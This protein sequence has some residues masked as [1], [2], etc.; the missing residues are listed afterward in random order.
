[1]EKP[2]T[3][4]NRH[5]FLSQK[6]VKIP[7]GSVLISK[8]DTRGIITYANDM[9][10]ETCGFSREELIGKSHNIVRHPDVPPSVFKWLWDTLQTGRPW[11]GIVK[12]RCK[13]GDHYWV[14]ATIA[15]IMDN[16]RVIGYVSVR[17]LPDLAE[18]HEAESVYRSLNESGKPVISRWE[19]F[20]FKN[21]T[22]K[23][24]L[25]FSILAPLSVFFLAGQF[26]V[27]AFLQQTSKTDDQAWMTLT[28]MS[29]MAV[30]LYFLIGYC[31]DRFVRQPLLVANKT[32]N[33]I[34]EGN[35]GNELDISTQDETGDLL[36][37]I[38]SMQCYLRTMVDEIVT[39]VG[40]I[41]KGIMDMDRRVSSVADNSMIELEHIQQIAST[42]EQFSQSVAEVAHMAS[43]SLD[44]ANATQK[45]IDV[46]TERMQQQI[47]PAMSKAIATAQ[48][49]SKT[50]VELSEAIKNIGV[51]TN[52]IKE[53][54][55]QTNLLALNAAI[56]AAR[57][58][59]QGRGFAVVADEVRKLAGRTTISTKDISS[60]IAEIT[61]IS[62]VAVK[63]MRDVVSDVEAGVVLVGLNGDGLR[64]IAGATKNILDRIEHI[65]QASKEQ[66][67]AGQDVARELEQIT[68]LVDG[69]TDSARSAK[70]EA[71]NLSVSAVELK[72]AGYPLT[73]CATA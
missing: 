20:K 2:I 66:S 15:P 29:V 23:S 31:S 22:I 38:Q 56:E 73:R 57:A 45:I 67:V 19:R 68:R 32:L 10:V 53:I 9:F 41:Q 17:S 50:I 30:F 1:M 37:A 18:I 72:K 42:M 36:C 26:V 39:P 13:N 3:M 58:G 54:A 35:L 63:S 70:T 16:G 11:R 14:K 44:D 59:D 51:I 8:A 25:R 24:K 43:E 47:T 49:S 64:E 60:T 62:D 6:E 7:Q 65:A 12:N 46:N 34:M 33:D 5:A 27:W 48:T 40:H 21:W 52:T 28:G 4:Q 61:S 69:N 71:N 55:E